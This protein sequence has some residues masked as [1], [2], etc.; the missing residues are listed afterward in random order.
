MHSDDRKTEMGGTCSTA[1]NKECGK[2]KCKNIQ[3]SRSTCSIFRRRGWLRPLTSGKKLAMHQMQGVVTP[4]GPV[5]ISATAVK[6]WSS[7]QD[8]NKGTVNS[9]R[10]IAALWSTVKNSHR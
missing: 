2:P 10:P 7:G 3:I 9:Q 1:E 4:I 6:I 5:L 8:R